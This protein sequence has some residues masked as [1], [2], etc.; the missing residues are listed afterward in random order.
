M[1]GRRRP[2]RT[3]TPATV[4]ARYPAFRSGRVENWA[5]RSDD[6]TWAYERL[7][8]A[9]TPWEVTHLPTGT[10]G[11]WYGTLPAARAGTADGSALAYVEL[12]LAHGR[13]EHAAARVPACGRC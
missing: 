11:P 12:A 7:E 2:P 8:Q 10:A 13:G 3:L 5:A 9:G 4:T 1:T 6:G